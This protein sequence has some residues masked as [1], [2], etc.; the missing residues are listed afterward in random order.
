MPVPGLLELAAWV[1]NRMM[2]SWPAPAL[3]S[4]ASVV[5]GSGQ[6]GWWGTLSGD[7]GARKDVPWAGTPVYPHVRTRG[8]V[9]L[10]HRHTHVGADNAAIPSHT[11]FA[12]V[13]IVMLV[14]V[15]LATALVR[16]KAT[17]PC[18][19]PRLR[20]PRSSHASLSWIRPSQV[21]LPCA[22]FVCKP[23]L[24]SSAACAST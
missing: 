24:V 10:T 11:V 1:T 9:A 21:V 12:Y 5:V 7:D 15:F 19:R 14:T 20:A 3:P 13:G 23:L 2:P 6:R 8:G 17:S 16:I 18:A 4:N 22:I